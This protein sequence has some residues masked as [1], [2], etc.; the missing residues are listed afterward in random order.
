MLSK[1]RHRTNPTNTPAGRLCSKLQDF[2]GTGNVYAYSPNSKQHAIR[3]IYNG[4]TNE[5]YG[6]LWDANGN[7]A[8]QTVYSVNNNTTNYQTMR[9]LFWDED[10]RLN[11]VAGDGYL[12]YYAYSH[13]GNRTI[14]M[15]GTATIDQNG[16]LQNTSNLNNITIYPSEYLTVTQAEYT[17]YYYAGGNRISSKISMGGFEKM[18]HLCTQDLN[19]SANAN[20]LFGN[21]LQQ[22]V[23]AANQPTD[24]YPATVCSGYIV[25]TELLTSQLPDFYISNTA[26]NFTQNNLLQQFRQNLAG[27]T[28]AVYYFH[29]DHL[30]S[31]SWITDGTGAA[32]Q[33][34]QYLP[35]G[36]HF[37]NEQSSGYFER[38]T[39]TGKERDA[40]TGYYYHGARFNCS[41]I[42]WL[43]VDPMSDKYSSWTPYNYCAWNPLKCVDPEGEEVYMLF[44]TKGNKRGDEMFKAAALT[45]KRDIENSDSY[46]KERDIVVLYE[47]SDLS[48]IQGAVDNI[49]KK[50]GE[51]YGKTKEFD[52][53]SHGSY[54]GP[55]G[56]TTTGKNCLDNNSGSK[57]MSKS[58]WE[59]IN[60]DWADNAR[61]S[62]YGCRTGKEKDGTS[63]AQRLS[64]CKNFSNVLVSGMSDNGFPSYS[65]IRYLEHSNNYILSHNKNV[66]T[67]QPTYMVSTNKYKR[68]ISNI[69][70]PPNRYKNGKKIN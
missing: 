32:V 40:E 37:V 46:N 1:L 44:Y 34:L 36:E 60:F 5:L 65:P 56:A 45:R 26:L 38:F 70:S 16:V 59:A 20:T 28:E 13:D 19:L 57:Q 62:F 55:S 49:Q 27:G 47:V 43:S 42:G 3:R 6:L 30:G 17:K 48:S 22:V 53:W 9:M 29:S 52:L 12:S 21:A 2:T 51:K 66:T 25:A 58:G 31:A 18:Q 33:H 68:R 15:T 41:D 64:N 23:N 39:F 54:D 63:F 69:C 11:L 14:K 4:L 24:E 35:F 10:D 61:A 50:Y 67:F 7:L 8:Q